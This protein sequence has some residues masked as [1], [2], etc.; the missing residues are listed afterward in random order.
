MYT[1]LY[2]G[3]NTTVGYYA[4]FA[5]DSADDY[6]F[7]FPVPS[8][9]GSLVSA[10]LLMIPD[11]TET[12]Q[13]DIYTTVAAAG[14]D[15]EADE[16]QSLN[17]QQAVTAEKLTEIDISG[18]LTGIAAEDYVGVIFTSNTSTEF[19]CEFRFTYVTASETEI[20]TIW[21]N[22]YTQQTGV[23]TSQVGNW[24]LN[25]L[26]NGDVMRF[27]FTVPPDFS[28]LSKAYLVILPDDDETLPI[29]G[30][31]EVAAPGEAYNND[32]RGPVTAPSVT[33]KNI[34]EVDF[35]GILT[36]LATGDYVGVQ[37]IATANYL[38]IV[39]FKFEY[40]TV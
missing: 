33:D 15:F 3:A 23:V 5:A 18:V 10:V 36:G 39:G 8:D 21:V 11:A 24:P 25:I 38:R 34:T 26:G 29:S 31:V 27:G 2:S 28:S 13:W 6:G 35:S 1:L 37:I 14:E 30:Y 20:N 16:R 19:V 17:V 40:N 7:N 4:A 12:I 22:G 32:A 9:F